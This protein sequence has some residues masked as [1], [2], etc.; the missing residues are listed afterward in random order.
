MLGVVTVEADDPA[1]QLLRALGMNRLLARCRLGGSLPLVSDRLGELVRTNSEAILAVTL[2]QGRGRHDQARGH[3][4]ERLPGPDTH[5]ETVAYGAAGDSMSALCTLMV[6]D[7]TR[8]GGDPGP[9][10]FPADR[11]LTGQGRAATIGGWT[12]D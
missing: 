5:I 1:D 3:L 8:R 6:G 9:I 7:G 12:T 4:V 11:R 2:A 10:P